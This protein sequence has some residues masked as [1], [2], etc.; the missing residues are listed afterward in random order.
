VGESRIQEADL[1]IAVG[2][3]FDDRVTGDLRTTPR[4]HAR[5]TSKIDAPEINKRRKMDAAL[6]G[7]AREVWSNCSCIDKK[8]RTAWQSRIAE[9]KGDSAFA[10]S[11]PAGH[12]PPVRRARD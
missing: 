11:E 1:L 6:V 3:R 12:R 2:L 8:E 9:M 7:D 10:I 5:F 4:A